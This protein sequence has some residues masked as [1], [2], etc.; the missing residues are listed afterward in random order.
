MMQAPVSRLG[1]AI[2]NRRLPDYSV[3]LLDIDKI[4]VIVNVMLTSE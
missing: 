3:R 1:L 2:I 4:T